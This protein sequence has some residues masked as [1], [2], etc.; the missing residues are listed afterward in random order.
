LHGSDSL[1]WFH[2]VQIPYCTIFDKLLSFSTI[3]CCDS[4]TNCW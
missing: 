2:L 4:G 3:C 1:F